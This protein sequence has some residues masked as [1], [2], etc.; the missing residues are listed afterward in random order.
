MEISI[1]GKQIDIGS[2]LQEYVH[3]RLSKTVGKYFDKAISSEVVFSKQSHKH[4]NLY[5]ADI[6][7]NEGSKIGIIKGNANSDDIRDSFNNALDKIENRLRRYKS[8]IKNHHKVKLSDELAYDNESAN[9]KGIKYILSPYNEEQ[10]SSQNELDNPV[11]IAEKANS[12]QTLTVSEA[13]MKMDL[14]DLPALLFRN[15]NNNRINVVYH[16]NDGNIS[17]IDSSDV[18]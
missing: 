10:D 1:A 2:S 5:Q 14:A 7:V 13:V 9:I 16:R 6:L 12:I 15:K 11:I 18:K 4:E 3:Q 8:K 17:W